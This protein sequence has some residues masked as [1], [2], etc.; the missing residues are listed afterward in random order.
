MGK[1]L[2]SAITFTLLAAVALGGVA[3][4]SSGFSD[5]TADGWQD[6]LTPDVSEEPPVSSE[7]PPVSS[8]EY[9]LIVNKNYGF[10]L[11]FQ[12]AGAITNN[13]TLSK[14]FNDYS[15]LDSISINNTQYDEQIVVITLSYPGEENLYSLLAMYISSDIYTSCEYLFTY[16]DPV[17]NDKLYGTYDFSHIT[18]TEADQVLNPI[19][20]PF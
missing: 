5:W 10:S 13:T 19:Y 1:K 17:S 16:L 15:N 2:T 9:R 7:E 4:L 11:D 18:L 14:N 20:T 8:E 6:R 3:Y 12:D